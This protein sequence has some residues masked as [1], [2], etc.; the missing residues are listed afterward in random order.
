MGHAVDGPLR[1]QCRGAAA[2]GYGLL[3]GA[4]PFTM[5]FIQA[6]AGGA[7]LRMLANMMFSEAYAHGGKLTGIFMVV[8]FML[9]VGIVLLERT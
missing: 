3:G 6:F 9:S 2:A 7:I 1:H 4:S 5:A 8:G